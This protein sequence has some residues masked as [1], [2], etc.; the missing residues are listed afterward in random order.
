MKKSQEDRWI[1]KYGPQKIEDRETKYA[2][3]EKEA[4]KLFNKYQDMNF[5]VDVFKETKT[6]KLN[7]LT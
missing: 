5:H 2:F 1:I 3:S 6:T 4:I 7:K